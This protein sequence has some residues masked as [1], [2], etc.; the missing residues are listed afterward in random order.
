MSRFWQNNIICIDLE[1]TGANPTKDR[2]TEIGIVELFPNGSSREWHRLINPETP[3][4]PFISRLTGISNEMVQD[5][6]LFSEIAEELFTILKDKF[7]VAHNVRFDYAFIKQ[8]FLKCGIHFKENT[9][10]TVR[11]SRQLYPNHFKHN[12]DSIIER[13]GIE[14]K[15]R[16]RALSDAKVV[17]NFLIH[18]KEHF[19][20]EQVSKAIQK[21][22]KKPSLPPGIDEHEIDT[23]PE[24]PGVYLFYGE[25]DL[26]IYIG[27]SINLRERVLSHFN[28]DHKHHKELR[29]SQQ[30]K[31]I[32]HHDTV[33]ELGALLLEAKLIKELNPVHNHRLRRQQQL[34]SWQWNSGNNKSLLE[35]KNTDEIN[36]SQSDNYFGVFQTRKKALDTL[37]AI[38][39]A[40]G[41]CLALLGIDKHSK[42]KACFRAQINKCHGACCGKEDIG[43]H[44]LKVQMALEKLRLQNWKWSGAIVIKESNHSQ[45]DFHLIDQWAYFGTYQSYQDALEANSTRREVIFDYDVYKILIKFIFKSSEIIV[46]PN[47]KSIYH[48]TEDYLDE[49][50]IGE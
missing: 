25:N 8:E 46:L 43:H 41:L 37:R 15:D 49:S 34:C 14:V 27:K 1:T 12:L 7:F 11:L 26:P 18:A 35:I 5:A 42:G 13:L 19:S 4:P 39:D 10:C 17:A 48:Q 23:L 38:A 44:N 47:N 20:E 36:F 40:H 50:L 22:T 3:I 45:T 16:H 31:R 33:G 32:E 30:I 21:V 29:L 28:S 6:P 9:L 24:S 2:I